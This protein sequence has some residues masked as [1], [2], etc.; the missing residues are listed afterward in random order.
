VEG[1]VFSVFFGAE[2]DDG[3]VSFHG[4]YFGRLLN[5]MLDAAL[6]LSK[7]TA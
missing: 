4:C 5:V 3:T 1:L 6:K 2:A 7:V